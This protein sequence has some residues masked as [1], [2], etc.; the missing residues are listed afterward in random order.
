MRQRCD[1]Q[2]HVGQRD[3]DRLLGRLD[4][5]WDLRVHNVGVGVGAMDPRAEN[6]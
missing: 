5:E 6:N 2:G 4:L 3:L 1:A